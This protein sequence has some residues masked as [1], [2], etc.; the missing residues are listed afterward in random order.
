MTE[1]LSTPEAAQLLG[2]TTESFSNL[3]VRSGLVPAG[4]R[5]RAHLYDQA[6]VE[7]LA[8]KRAFAAKALR[9]SPKKKP[10]A[11]SADQILADLKDE[12]DEPYDARAWSH[13][14]RSAKTVELDAPGRALVFIAHRDG[15]LTSKSPWYGVSE[16]P[17]SYRSAFE[18]EQ[19]KRRAKARR[20][21]QAARE[22]VAA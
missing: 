15:T 6:D 17:E 20:E 21:Q 22:T 9:R 5:G 11:P 2:V 14:G 3:R 7:R 12:P 1:L 8:A 19:R 13:G 16:L 18:S 10:E 4:R